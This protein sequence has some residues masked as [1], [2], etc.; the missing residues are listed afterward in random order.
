MNITHKDNYCKKGNVTFYFVSQFPKISVIYI[1]DSSSHANSIFE[2]TDI[3]LDM[4]FTNTDVHRNHV[5]SFL[6]AIMDQSHLKPHE[7]NHNGICSTLVTTAALHVF[8]NNGQA[9]LNRT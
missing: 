6:H 7:V 8:Q 9:Q 3:L 2:S 1:H 5:N 4:F